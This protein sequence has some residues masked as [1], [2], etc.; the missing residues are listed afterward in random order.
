MG[1]GMATLAA[2]IPLKRIFQ[3]TIK[4][5]RFSLHGILFD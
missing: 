1:L 4:Y 2:L 3:V 5:P